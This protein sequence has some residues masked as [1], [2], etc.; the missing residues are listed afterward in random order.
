MNHLM[1]FFMRGRSAAVAIN[2]HFYI[3]WCTR[4]FPSLFCSFFPCCWWW[5]LHSAQT[6]VNSFCLF[7]SFYGYQESD[8]DI[9]YIRYIL[10]KKKKQSDI[11]GWLNKLGR[12]PIA[13]TM[14]LN[15]YL[16]LID[17]QRPFNC[18]FSIGVCS[19]FSVA[20]WMSFTRLTITSENKWKS[21]VFCF[22][23]VAV[24]V[25]EWTSTHRITEVIPCSVL[26]V[27]IGTFRSP[28]I[29]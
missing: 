9:K 5:K 2:E 27:N 28:R 11:G 26:D 21:K 17:F 10:K 22:C 19:E 20:V 7:V 1:S 3:D 23:A 12:L 15:I 13:H 29:H 25:V 16:K 18:Q 8:P 14:L 6:V 4:I 24:F